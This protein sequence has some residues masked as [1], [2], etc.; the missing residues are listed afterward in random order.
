MSDIKLWQYENENY[1]KISDEEIIKLIKSGDKSALDYI[2]NKY[3][4]VVNI[5][6]RYSS[7]RL[8]SDYIRLLKTLIVI[9]IILLKLLQICVLKDN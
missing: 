4:E 2:M 1:N 8:N 9:K 6:V 5:K 3:K 7:R